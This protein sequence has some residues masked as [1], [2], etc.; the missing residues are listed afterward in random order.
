MIDVDSFENILSVV[1][2]CVSAGR[3]DLIEQALIDRQHVSAVVARI[4]AE[5]TAVPAEN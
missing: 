3:A 1:R 2:T 4:E 5:R